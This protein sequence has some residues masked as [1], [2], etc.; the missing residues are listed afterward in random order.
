MLRGLPRGGRVKSSLSENRDRIHLRVTRKARCHA[1][2]CG[3]ASDLRVMTDSAFA[4]FPCAVA[5]FRA[6]LKEI[7]LDWKVPPL[8]RSGRPTI[9]GR[10][11]GA[12]VA[13]VS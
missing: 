4:D 11:G 13:P 9:T 1:R 8:T 5:R 12:A 2:N 10:A 7:E 3:W 6:Q